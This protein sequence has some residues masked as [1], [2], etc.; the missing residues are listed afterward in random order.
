[1]RFFPLE[2]QRY[3][4][5]AENKDEALRKFAILGD[6][7]LANQI[8][9]SH[10]FMY[11]HRYWKVVKDVIENAVVG[12]NPDT[13]LSETIKR[14]SKAAADQ[15]R[16]D[17]SLTTA[18]T[19]AGLMTL[20]QAGAERFKAAPGV[21]HKASKLMSRSPNEIV[22]ARN[23][24]DSQGLLGFLKTVDKKFSVDY[25][26]PQRTGSFRIINDEEIA[27]AA[28]RDQSGNWAAEDPR[29]IEGVIP[30]ECRS[31]ACGTCWVG[32]LAGEEKLSEVAPLERKQVK[33]F[34]YRQPEGPKPYLRLACQARAYGNATIVIPPWNGV[35]GKKIYGDIEEAVLEPATTSAKRN[36]EVIRESI[37]SDA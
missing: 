36:R 5:S 18:I 4:G 26:S 23:K 37:A 33:I 29:C 22:A 34:G 24:D 21:V 28:A 19:I 20:V 16:V 8:D 3:L 27:S 6:H 2:L 9:S 32:V 14:L 10:H 31:A 25:I 12:G 17:P 11:G 13:S 15:A 1:M 30:V 35:F 7:E